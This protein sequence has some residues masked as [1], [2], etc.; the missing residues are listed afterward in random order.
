ME[1]GD[2]SGIKV[3]V[4]CPRF[5]HPPSSP[6]PVGLCLFAWKTGALARPRQRL[7]RREMRAAAH[8][9]ASPLGHHQGRYRPAVRLPALV[10]SGSHV[11]KSPALPPTSHTAAWSLSSA[12]AWSCQPCFNSHGASPSGNGFGTA[13]TTPLPARGHRAHGQ[14]FSM[15]GFSMSCRI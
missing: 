6:A 11:S 10:G 14:A 13:S 4:V 1:N 3:P 12:Y 7:P 5:P 8:P 2:R 15:S 9:L